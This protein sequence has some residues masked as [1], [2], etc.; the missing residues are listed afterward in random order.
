[1]CVGVV[2]GFEQLQLGEGRGFGQSQLGEGRGFR[3]FWTV[4]VR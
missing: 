1:M 4:T 2:R 3:Q